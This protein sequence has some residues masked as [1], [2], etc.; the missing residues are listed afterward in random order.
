MSQTVILTHRFPQLNLLIGLA[1]P[2]AKTLLL[3]LLLALLGS[4]TALATPMV[5]K[6]VL[7]T[8][9]TS[10]S[11]AAPVAALLVLLVVGS[12]VSLWQWILLGSTAERIVLGVRE[13]MVRRFLH[14]TVGSLAKR[15]VGELVTRV[16]SDT[17]L[18][19]EATS[20]SAIGIINGSVMLVGT[21]VLMSVLDRVLLG[22][23][24]VAVTLVVII[25]ISLMPSI[26]TAKEQSQQAIGRLGGVLE[27]AIRAIKTVKVS[28]AEARQS[29]RLSHEA[30]E[31][32]RHSIRSIRREGVALTIAF[33]GIQLAIIA[34]LGVG[35]WR[36]TEGELEVSSFIAFL[37][38]AFGLM[39][40]IT[41]LSTNIGNLQSGIAAAGRMRELDTLESETH[42]MRETRP[43]SAIMDPSAG[44][45]PVLELRGVTAGYGTDLAPA[46]K[47]ITLSLPARG[48]VAIVGPSGSG[49][50]TLF[51]LILHFIPP[52]QGEL[53]LDGRAYRM[54]T[55][56]EIRSRFAYV[57][58]DTPI[59]P[60]TIAD[61][62]RFT[63]PDAS[64]E[65][66]DIALRKVRLDERIGS[67][68]SGLDTDL[69]AAS[70]SGGERQRIALARAI[71]RAPDILLLD[72]AT[73]QVDAITEAAIH[74][75]IREQ[76]KNGA[77]I[78]IAHRLS[79]VVDA[80]MIIVLEAGRVRA[81]GTHEELLRQDALYRD[82][83]EALRIAHPADA[84]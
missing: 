15:P 61:N 33:S 35:S 4:A 12:A 75:C 50:T 7:D 72:E 6:W 20:S 23:T 2:H 73:A 48:H 11:M 21:L 37:L 56:A 39:G 63:H 45:R 60:G 82:L 10:G 81:R 71:L 70:I 57:E 22:T 3:G 77:V 52:Q 84:S 74:E 43:V 25:F 78:T 34:I 24:L 38:Y 58:Q 55:H 62:L 27:G 83:V 47:D 32:A 17:V 44:N 13:N 8:I 69:N 18:L 41:E 54:L 59:I 28:R 26:A 68:P 9:A 19:R 66:I 53:F 30:R 42:A 51:S 40:P 46:V 16:T 29:E 79:T 65:E 5:T 64:K 67:L 80:D 49:K 36:V 14:A 76:A 1:R 31:S